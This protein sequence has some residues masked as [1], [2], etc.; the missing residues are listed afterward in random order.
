MKRLTTLALALALMGGACALAAPVDAG[1]AGQVASAYVNALPKARAALSVK[2]VEK[3]AD[4][5][6]LV[7]F[8][9]TGFAIVSADDASQP[10][11]S[12]G[13]DQNLRRSDIPENMQF[14]LSEASLTVQ[15]HKQGPANSRWKAIESGQAVRMARDNEPID[16]LIKVR[17]NQ[18]S[19]YNKYCPG[20]GKN[21]ALVGCVAVAMSQ[22]MSVQK[23][24]AQPTGYIVYNSVNYNLLEVDL[25]KEPK[26]DWDAILSGSNQF[27]AAARLMWH[28]G[29]SVEMDYGTDGSGIPS[30]QTYRI[31]NA[32]KNNFGYPNAQWYSRESYRGD[33]DQLV[34]NELQAGRAV[35]YNAIDTKGGYG[36][37]FNVDGYDGD[38]MYHLNWGWGGI[39]NGYFALDA[40]KDEAMDMN[41]DSYHRV[42]T[43]IGGTNSPLKSLELSD[44][45][46]EE[47]TPAGTAVAALLV[48]G[49]MPVD[50]DVRVEVTG[51]YNKHSN[52]YEAV[53]FK[54]DK[55]LIYTTQQLT[56]SD[57][58]VYVRVQVTM[59]K[60]TG[61]KLTQGFNINVT[62]PLPLESRS[63]VAYDRATKQFTVKCKF[64]STYTVK[65]SQGTVV[66]SGTI[67]EKPS[68]TFLRSQL[69][70]G[71]NTVELSYGSKTKTF[72][73]EL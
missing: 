2:S 12:Y 17:W 71:R 18:P 8:A 48:N 73:I 41:Y 45:V 7:N 46:V 31:T 62:A 66:C 33:W 55:G 9:P 49:A 68:F 23:Y 52:E 63:A 42:V 5:L 29:M 54:Y 27:D 25:D 67:A 43:G 19:P 30:T 15:L 1:R 24:P 34:L 57:K 10:I 16:E 39:G 70:P 64:G 58:P 50:S 28:A 26:Y 36:H 61:I 47:D 32:L 59:K 14:M 13:L 40:L 69:T 72:A 21:K 56:A 44:M 4:N 6:Y 22:A 60:E 65:N 11:V 3:C 20:E 37:S 51:E 38:G 35:V 53:P